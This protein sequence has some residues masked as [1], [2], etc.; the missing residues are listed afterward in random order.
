MIQDPTATRTEISAMLSRLHYSQE[1]MAQELSF[2]TF[3]SR[4]G[5][6]LHVAAAA[7]RIDGAER[8]L[9]SFGADP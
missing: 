1:I 6:L 2:S 5:T 8:L 4:Y 3:E 7:G 9:T